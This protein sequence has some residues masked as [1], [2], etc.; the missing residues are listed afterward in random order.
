[1][2]S[3][4]RSGAFTLVELLVVIAIIAVLISL[5]L[6]A[7]GRVRAAAN[8]VKCLSN[9]RQINM[10]TF[11][12]VESHDGYLFKDWNNA[13]PN[14]GE[15]SWQYRFPLEG[16]SYIV[17][18]VARSKDVLGCPADDSGARW[19]LWTDA[20]FTGAVNPTDYAQRHTD[21]D[22]PASYRWNMSHFPDGNRSIKLTQ[23]RKASETILIAEGVPIGDY[24]ESWLATW[25]GSTFSRVG[26][27]TVDNVAYKRH[28]GKDLKTGVS[29]FGFADGHASTVAWP[30]T[31]RRI[32]GSDTNPESPW[33]AMYVNSEF[34]NGSPL[35]NAN[36]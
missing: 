21:D 18:Q 34:N 29:N 8:S 15:T 31:W 16:W 1:M 33:R 27:G 11:L 20:N 23:L 25:S 35:N 14:W 4:L 22:L 12:F 17:S 10:A 30:D 6:P 7:L 19:G 36:P 9:I 3:P 32:G 24:P 13:G 2:T 26:R 28:G 5:L